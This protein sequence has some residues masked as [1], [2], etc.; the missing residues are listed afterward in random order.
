MSGSCSSARVR[1]IASARR[2]LPIVDAVRA[3]E[4]CA[5][6]ACRATSRAAWRRGRKKRTGRAGLRAG[7]GESIISTL[8]AESTRR[9][10][11][12]WPADRSSGRTRRKRARRVV[13][14]SRRCTSVIGRFRPASLD[15][16][17]HSSTVHRSERTVRPAEA[18][19]EVEF[20]NQAGVSFALASRAVGNPAF[21]SGGWGAPYRCE[22][23]RARARCAAMDCLERGLNGATFWPRRPAL[24]RD[25]DLFVHD[26]AKLRRFRLSA[27]VQALFFC[28]LDGSRRLVR[29]C[30]RPADRTASRIACRNA[31]SR[32]NA[33]P[34]RSSS[35]RRSSKRS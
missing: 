23:R 14:D 22:I 17:Q 3:A 25:R 29:L 19:L 26:G 1:S 7:G 15:L 27:P 33:A 16:R 10:G 6:R 34:A 9:V 5:C 18:E 24:F 31:A 30:R 12:A 32:P 8:L 21:G 13:K 20:V 2:A 4:R 35:A 11:T 28:L